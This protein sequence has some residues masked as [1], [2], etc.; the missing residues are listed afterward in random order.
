MCGYSETQHLPSSSVLLTLT[1]FL[2][3]LS[4]EVLG[5]L[6]ESVTGAV[7]VDTCFD[8]DKS[9]A[10]VKPLLKQVVIPATLDLHPV[11]SHEELCE[12]DPGR[13]RAWRPTR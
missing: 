2:E 13:G 7:L 3:S 12:H 1:C 8:L 6:V 5:D 9:W 11:T 10:V 4:L